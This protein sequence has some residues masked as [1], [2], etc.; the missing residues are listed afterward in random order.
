ML[1]FFDL[2]DNQLNAPHE[3]FRVMIVQNVH[4]HALIAAS[5]E[6]IPVLIGLDIASN[7]RQYQSSRIYGF[8]VATRHLQNYRVSCRHDSH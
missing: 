1:N 8:K 4:V 2:V 6:R 3:P 7:S 5:K